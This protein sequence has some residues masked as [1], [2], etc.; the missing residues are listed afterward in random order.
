MLRNTPK[1]RR[2]DSVTAK[3][4]LLRVLAQ[5]QPFLPY[6]AA[7]AAVTVAAL[8]VLLHSGRDV[9]VDDKHF[10]WM[11]F[12]MGLSFGDCLRC[13][14]ALIKLVLLLSYLVG[15]RKLGVLHYFMLA[16]P[17]VIYAVSLKSPL[18]IPGRLLWL[19]L[20]AAALTI[21]NVICGYIRDMGAGVLFWLLY[22]LMAV[23]TALFGVYIFLTEVDDISA[24]RSAD[25]EKKWDDIEST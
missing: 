1:L 7:V 8:P 10:G 13:A 24:G 22:I 25:F 5:V 18:R 15:F 11:S 19:V 6:M 3:E 23:F 16:V 21:T 9:W 14:C 2:D 4:I 20:E 17:G 12:F